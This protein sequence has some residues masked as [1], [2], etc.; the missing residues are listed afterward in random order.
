MAR[1]RRQGL[2]AAEGQWV[3]APGGDGSRVP[4]GGRVRR[5]LARTQPVRAGALREGRRGAEQ[6]ARAEREESERGAPGVAGPGG[7]A[8]HAVVPLVVRSSTPYDG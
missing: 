5:Q 3:G 8:G 4:A 6:A 1:R 7:G 2:A